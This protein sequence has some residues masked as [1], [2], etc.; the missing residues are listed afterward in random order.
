MSG[1][2][3]SKFN[4]RG[5]GLVGSLGTDGQHLLSSGAGKTNVFETQAVVSDTSARQDILT[6]GLKQAV[7][8]NS[9]KF[10]LPN[11]A[12]TK[13]EADADFNLGG[14]TDIGRHASEYIFTAGVSAFSNDGNTLLLCHFDGSDTATSTTDSSSDGR[15]VSFGGNAQL[16]TAIKK[17]GTASLLLDGTGD[18]VSLPASSDWAYSGNHTIECWLYFT[19]L[20]SSP[21]FINQVETHDQANESLIR[22]DADDHFYY[23]LRNS[24]NARIL[25]SDESATLTAQTWHHFALVREGTAMRIYKDGVQTD[26]TTCT[27]TY[28]SSSAVLYFGGGFGTAMAGNMDEL[29]VSDNARYTGGTT[30]TP[31][32]GG[33]N[34]T[35]TALGTT[36]VPASAVTE[37]SGV[38]LLK[39]QA[40]TN[41]L[42]T[43]VKV[44]FTA[45]NSAWTEA[46]SY[47]DAGT[48]STGIKMIKLGKTTVS[49]GSDVRWKIVY[50]NQTGSKT[51]YIYGVGLNY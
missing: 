47:A 19:D 1:I 22:L 17:I 7:Q 31:N 43:D 34:A 44:Y 3:G 45:D 10:N 26:S 29:R 28:G 15:T 37:V 41:T 51:A 40:G 21:N 5:S 46:A 8:E 6:L 38:M 30:F 39:N 13:F 16:D 20:D 36:N 42:G 18:Y 35:G 49:S 2:I 14:S 27:G 9:T 48:F 33:V 50:A 12:I 25:P 24:A 11:A 23:E 32:A 4:H